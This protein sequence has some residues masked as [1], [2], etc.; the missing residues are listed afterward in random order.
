M[1]ASGAG[2]NFMSHFILFFLPDGWMHAID[3]SLLTHIEQCGGMCQGGGKTPQS[4][5]ISEAHSD[6]TL[7]Q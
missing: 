3:R 1:A 4:T 2:F 7:F 5:S 6:Q